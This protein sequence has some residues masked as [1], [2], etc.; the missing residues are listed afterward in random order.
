MSSHGTERLPPPIAT[1]LFALRS[2]PEGGAAA[3]SAQR[4]YQAR[5]R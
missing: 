4:T 5:G 2:D 3:G 1:D